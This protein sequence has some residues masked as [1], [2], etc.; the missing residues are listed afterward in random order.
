MATATSSIAAE[1]L[2]EAAIVLAV[3]D[4]A[5][6]IAGYIDTLEEINSEAY[7]SLQR[8][9]TL[10]ASRQPAAKYAFTLWANSE[11]L[12]IDKAPA[13]VIAFDAEGAPTS[14]PAVWTAYR[15]R[16]ALRRDIAAM[17]LDSESTTT[18]KAL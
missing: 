11:G 2:D 18:E 8:V 12:S 14:I 6:T 7:A 4:R 15:M 1:K 17:H 5:L 9:V 13:R 10:F 16:G 3:L